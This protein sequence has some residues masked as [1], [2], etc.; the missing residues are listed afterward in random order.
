MSVVVQKQASIPTA[1]ELHQNYMVDII[2]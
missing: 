2:I 1:T